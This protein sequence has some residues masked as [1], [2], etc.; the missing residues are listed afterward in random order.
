VREKDAANTTMKKAQD[1][2]KPAIS[3]LDHKSGSHKNQK[4]NSPHP[5]LLIIFYL[6]NL[7]FNRIADI[8]SG[9]LSLQTKTFT[10]LF[11]LYE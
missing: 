7:T 11:Q 6:L 5:L 3:L 2:N 10:D 8:S 4:N 9:S 1:V